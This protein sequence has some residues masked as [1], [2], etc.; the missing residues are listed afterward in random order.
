M[1]LGRSVSSVIPQLKLQA[2]GDHGG[3]LLRLRADGADL[4]P[5]VGQNTIL[6]TATCIWINATAKI[7]VPS[8]NGWISVNTRN[9]KINDRLIV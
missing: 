2:V 7:N 4:L 5:A 8:G 6:H 1:P 3:E 9:S